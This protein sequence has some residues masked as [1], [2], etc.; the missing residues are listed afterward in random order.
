MTILGIDPGSRVLGW[1]LFDTAAQTLTDVGFVRLQG[2][3]LGRLDQ[4]DLALPPIIALSDQVAMERQFSA[5]N[6]GDRLLHSIATLIQRACHR[7]GKPCREIPVASARLAVVGKGNAD[8]AAVRLCLHMDYGTPR[9]MALDMSDACC[10][11]VA[12]WLLPEEP[13]EAS[14]RRQSARSM[15]GVLEREMRGR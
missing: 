12:A 5:G 15:R 8:K 6:H 13:K 10:V 7:A 11:A 2:P 3:R 1:A 9:D 4:L 14:W